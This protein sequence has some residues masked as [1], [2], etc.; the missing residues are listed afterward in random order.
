LRHG[1]GDGPVGLLA[2]LASLVGDGLHGFTGLCLGPVA[3]CPNH[4]LLRLARSPVAISDAGKSPRQ[5]SRLS[6]SLVISLPFRETVVPRDVWTLCFLRLI[7][8]RLW[9]ERRE[10]LRRPIGPKCVLPSANAERL[11]RAFRET[12]WA[13]GDDVSR[14]AKPRKTAKAKTGFRGRGFCGPEIRSIF[15][16]AQ[17]PLNMM[18]DSSVWGDGADLDQESVPLPLARAAP[19]RHDPARQA[20]DL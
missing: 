1:N 11:S 3:A 10:C 17:Q 8:W 4:A 9:G 16:A 7:A 12:F 20:V 14:T 15:G 19:R 6:T 18:F 2:H 5:V 13:I